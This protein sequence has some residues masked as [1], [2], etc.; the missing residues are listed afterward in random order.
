MNRKE[1]L[2]NL[3]LPSKSEE[4]EKWPISFTE[5]NVSLLKKADILNGP[6][7]ARLASDFKYSRS[8][9]PEEWF[10]IYTTILIQMGFTIHSFN[11]ARVNEDNTVPQIIVVSATGDELLAINTS[12]ETMS[13]LQDGNFRATNV[14]KSVFCIVA[15]LN[16]DIYSEI[17]D[18]ITA[19]LGVSA[20]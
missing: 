10:T 15:V 13:K 11:F 17:R 18:I 9:H 6:L 7:F 8:E 20:N 16:A 19:R 12:L 14:G 2:S 4:E 3:E 1:F 5:D